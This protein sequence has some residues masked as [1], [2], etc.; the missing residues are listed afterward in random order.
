MSM[1]ELH[2]TI[3][4]ALDNPRTKWTAVYIAFVA[5][6]IAISN[7][8]GINA[9]K[10][11]VA[12]NIAASNLFA[13]FQAKN[14]RQTAY[15]IA[16]NDLQVTLAST[17]DLPVEA[18]RKIEETIKSYKAKIARYQSEPETGEG[19]K[20]LLARARKEQQA[21]ERATRQDPYFDYSQALLQIAIVLASVSL[22][23]SSTGILVLSV[24]TMLIGTA[25]MA[26]GFTLYYTVPFLG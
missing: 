1:D 23:T 10:E 26:N 20:E 11:A 18:R 19:K 12:S 24:L 3:E 14:M 13:F 6:L 21:R 2:E 22:I 17:P 4:E 9:D 15:K 5:I 7:M 8:G 25:L 16:A